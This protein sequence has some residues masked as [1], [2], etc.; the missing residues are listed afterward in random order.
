MAA[1]VKSEEEEKINN[2][3]T[4]EI[5][6]CNDDSTMTYKAVRWLKSLKS[7]KKKTV[8]GVEGL[9]TDENLGERSSRNLYIN[10]GIRS[11]K[12][13]QWTLEEMTMT[14][15]TATTTTTTT[16]RQKG[17]KS[18]M[19]WVKEVTAYRTF[20]TLIYVPLWI[21]LFCHHSVWITCWIDIVSGGTTAS[22]IT[23]SN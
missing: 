10:R 5:E 13:W 22:W 2:N 4:N 21:N 15:T 8:D 16:K 6:N 14:T 9:V 12:E 11:G 19:V 23:M 20:Q 17:T 7:M 18:N 1:M 3:I